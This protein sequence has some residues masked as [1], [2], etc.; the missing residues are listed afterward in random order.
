M[1]GVEKRLRMVAGRPASIISTIVTTP[2][3]SGSQPSDTPSPK[4]SSDPAT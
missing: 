1:V 2:A 3:T 4:S